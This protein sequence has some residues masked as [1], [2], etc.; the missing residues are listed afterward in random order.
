MTDMEDRDGIVKNQFA[1]ELDVA[2]HG[3]FDQ[4]LILVNPN[5]STPLAISISIW[6]L[7]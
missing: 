6:I 1:A 5:V 2:H 7:Y 4:D 3:S